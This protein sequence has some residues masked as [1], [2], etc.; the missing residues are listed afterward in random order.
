MKEY[1]VRI[2]LLV[3]MIAVTAK[4]GIAQP[5]P[6]RPITIVVGAPA[7]GA[8]DTAVRTISDRMSAALGQPIVIE[9]VPGAGGMTATAR[10]ARAI[11]DGYTLLVQQTGIATIPALYPNAPF[12]VQDDLTAVGLINSSYSFIVER[13][14]LPPNSFPELV[15]WMRKSGTS[16]KIGFPGVASFG[17]LW[18]LL[19][20]KAVDV[21]ADL[22]P[23]RGVAPLISDIVGQHI[24]LGP[25]N[26]AGAVPLIKNKSMKA[27][28]Y[29]STK[30]HAAVPD[31]PTY[32]EIGY[33]ALSRPLWHALFAPSATPPAIIE[34]LNT[35]LRETIADPKVRRA[36]ADLDLEAFASDRM[37]PAAANE[38]V[39]EEIL[40]MSE[41]IKDAN[42]QPQ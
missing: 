11:P 26:A 32:A 36:Y 27:Y 18:S 29:G 30:R 3:G 6:Q 2:A 42:I 8:G 25:A 1:L 23:Y 15:D 28:V 9:N 13:N 19:M 35:A 21:K 24:D 39:R 17:H 22:V 14:S 20:L 37:T 7:G 5:Y 10:V 12:K 40:R 16:V 38:Y 41:V 33:P 31:V 34:R 4:L